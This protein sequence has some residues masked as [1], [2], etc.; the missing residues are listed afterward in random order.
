MGGGDLLATVRKA[1]ALAYDS[2]WTARRTVPMRDLA[3]Y[4]A[5]GTVRSSSAPRSS[6]ACPESRN[7][8]D[9]GGVRST[10]LSG[11]RMLLGIGPSGRR[12]PG[13]ALPAFARHLHAQRSRRRAGG[14][15]SRASASSFTAS[16]IALPLPDGPAGLKRMTLPS[17]S[18]SRSTLARDRPKNPSLAC[19]IAD[20]WIP[21]PVLAEHV[22]VS[23][24]QLLRDGAARGGRTLD[25]LSN[26]APVRQ[27]GRL[28]DHESPAI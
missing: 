21:R 14:M 17:L 26:I 5:A 25:G 13:L 11:G 22:I 18:R 24:L 3:P 6:N 27:L 4:V 23:F 28:R 8:R 10:H 7:D 12:S 16:T 19:E 20:G 15:L 2:A 1:E 9:D